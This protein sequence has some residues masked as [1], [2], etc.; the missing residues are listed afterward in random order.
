MSNFD[1]DDMQ[2]L[3]NKYMGEN[4]SVNEVLYHLGSRG[5]GFNLLPWQRKNNIP[6]ILYCPL[7]QGG[8]LKRELLR[9][10][11]LNEIAEEH[12]AKPLKI[13]LAWTIRGNDII[14]IPKASNR[15]GKGTCYFFNCALRSKEG[16]NAT[17]RIFFKVTF[18]IYERMSDHCNR[19]QKK[20]CLRI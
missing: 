5:I 13:A 11:I 15:L 6:T 1:T 16:L 18:Q 17:R 8:F 14:S 10:E 20:L 4:C 9:N 19:I 7:A 3:L 12:D 2:E